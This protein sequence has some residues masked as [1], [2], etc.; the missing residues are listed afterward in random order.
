MNWKSNKIKWVIIAFLSI[1]LSWIAFTISYKTNYQKEHAQFQKEFN[2][3][4][5]KQSRFANS[6]KK[7]IN[8]H[9][10]ET[11]WKNENLRD[12]EYSIA[13][14]KSDSLL[15][16]NTDKI[17]LKDGY[18][19]DSDHFV[20]G[21]AN[22][23]YLVDHFE[24]DDLNVFVGSN[25]KED[26]YYTNSSLQNNVSKHFSTSNKIEID[27]E[28]NEHNSPI[29]SKDGTPIFY[30]TILKEKSI[31]EF[32]QLITFILYS[33]GILSLLIAISLII[34]PYCKGRSFLI[35]LYPTLLLSLRYLSIRFGWV[36]FFN[37]FALFDPGLFAISELI[38]NLGSLI[39]SLIVFSVIIWWILYFIKR[40]PGSPQKRR[41]ILLIAY[42]GI[43]F[44]SL[45]ISFIF[46]SL[47]VNSSILLVLDEVFNLSLYSILA[48]IVITSLFFSYYLLIKRLSKVLIDTNIKLNQLA[49]IWFFSSIAFLFFSTLTENIYDVLL[50]ILLNGLFF[51]L[52]AKKLPLNS[53]KYHLFFII[54]FSFYS[55]VILFQNNQLNEHQT[56]ELYANQL[57]TDQDPTMEMEYE[58]TMEQLED[59]PE[60]IQL[61]KN[62][63]YFSSADFSFQLENCCFNDF[64][65]RYEIDFLFFREDGSP[66]FGIENFQSKNEVE[67]I[68]KY[69]SSLSSIAEGL[70][71]V[72]DYYKQLSYLGHKKI[73][74]EE[75][76]YVDFYILFK[77]KKIPEKIGFPR[78]LMNEQSY[79]LQYLEDYSIARFSNGK[80]VMRFGEYNFPTN[81][82]ASKFKKVK[83]GFLTHKGFSHFIYQQD[84]GQ[85]V[86][87]SKPQKK[88]IEKLSTFSYLVLFFGLY[89]LIAVILLKWQV[90]FPLKSLHLSLKVQ[91][92]LIFMVIGAFIVF[93]IVAIQNVREQFNVNTSDN[94][95]E[96]I[97]AIDKEFNTDI[98]TLNADSLFSFSNSQKI[99]LL[100]KKLSSTYDTD[101][102]F[103]TEGGDLLATSQPK[104][105]AKG[106]SAPIMNSS[107][108][109]AMYFD[110]RSEFIHY[111]NYGKLKFLSGYLP[112]KNYSDETLGFLNIQHFSKQK[113]FENQMNKF[114]VTV[115]NLTI[116]IL[117][118][119]VIIVIIVSRWVTT[120]LRLIRQSFLRVEL[121]K[122][123]QPIDYKG[124]DE[125]GDLVK[126]YN[127]KLKELELKAMQLAKS[128]RETAWREMAK[129]VA[130][131]IKNPLTPMKLSVQQF[132]RSFDP[133]ATDAEDRIKR[134]VN[135]L[136]EQ[137][138]GLTK[139]A[140]EFS[141]FAKM[142]KANEEKLDL[143]PIIR[144]T[145][146][147]YS[148][149]DVEIALNFNQDIAYEIFADKDLI[150]RVF[151]NLI[152]NAIQ[153]KKEEEVMLIEI[154]VDEEEANYKIT[155]SDNG[156]GMTEEVKKKIFSP[157][158]TTKSTGSGL[159]LAMVQQIIS[160]H[161][162]E[163]WF[164][165]ELGKGTSF[166]ISL[167]KYES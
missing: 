105:Y 137:I 58:L 65:E 112:L 32:Q 103:F 99:D 119:T 28:E 33:F 158:F 87:I 78:L 56:R 102:N 96:K 47:I 11:I 163:I 124:D 4:E 64:W 108:Y 111:E 74:L 156:M 109:Y 113:I 116:L 89:S 167:P 166:Y 150:I 147:L 23:Y 20:D 86:I 94:L 63:D 107:A 14:Y 18:S 126:D 46:K 38:P 68:I 114:I 130:H 84:D 51:Y 35:L 141:N 72:E 151:N 134:L 104:L 40:I 55:A 2:Q 49:L 80:L 48:L 155:I 142:P 41:I 139:I 165:S 8:Q 128:E 162:G 121:G 59:N 88:F 98:H 160:T 70:Y 138:D 133:Q 61:V 92:V 145:K 29:L 120:P 42:V 43:L 123:N 27:W 100:L 9:T 122:E 16:W 85:A 144:N 81:I 34:L 54:I 153:A 25:I 95:K 24:L 30:L 44:Y 129:Q 106:I 67:H 6:L 118:I 83:N 10:I 136:I 31:G 5:D 22:G 57:V 19:T 79:A 164:E 77:S 50:P 1:I 62:S 39:L 110:S 52:T 143:L 117:V 127:D 93:G 36:Y 132:Q 37:N 154:N 125:I 26:F 149:A 131:E 90:I 157:N 53:L 101:I 82:G 17:E 97:Y 3:L 73:E 60:F 140:N 148:S 7:V 159:G 71:F 91:L 146:E 152:K 76:N 115:I 12:S 161:N 69:N 21:Y 15:Y 45:F 13:I 66:I 75:G 135:S